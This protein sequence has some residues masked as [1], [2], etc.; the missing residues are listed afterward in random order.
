[1]ASGTITRVAASDAGMR[2]QECKQA[3]QHQGELQPLVDTLAVL[4]V[5]IVII[6]S[7]TFVNGLGQPRE[8]TNR[9]VW[10]GTQKCPI[11]SIYLG[12]IGTD[13]RTTKRIGVMDENF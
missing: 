1:M 12:F 3:K 6:Y 7:R 5:H 4:L 8:K 2:G 10:F 9:L 13:E 11:Y